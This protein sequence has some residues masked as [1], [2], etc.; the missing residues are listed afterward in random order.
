MGTST[1]VRQLS[2]TAEAAPTRSNTACRP[3]AMWAMA[4]AAV[5]VGGSA[6]RPSPSGGAGASR[7]LN[8]HVGSPSMP[9]AELTMRPMASAM[10]WVVGAVEV[11]SSCCSG[12]AAGAGR[13]VAGGKEFI[14]VL[15]WAAAVAA[16]IGQ[17]DEAGR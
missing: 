4:L 12:G 6:G 14:L 17:R 2:G 11:A 15:K 8:R 7:G 9:A 13:C 5:A 10:S 16:E 3:A 1:A